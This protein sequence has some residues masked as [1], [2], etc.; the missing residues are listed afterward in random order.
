MALFN[1]G[2]ASIYLY[3]MMLLTDYWGENQFR[4]QIGWSLLFFLSFIVVVNFTKVLAQFYS[5]LSRKIKTHVINK[6]KKY[7][8]KQK[9]PTVAIKTEFQIDN[10]LTIT[11]S[12]DFSL[13]RIPPYERHM[14]NSSDYSTVGYTHLGRT[15]VINEDCINRDSNKFTPFTDPLS[16]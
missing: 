9:P 16:R 8:R 15:G 7:L 2:A 10:K 5:Y 4:D 12:Q 14:I 13:E 3:I 1:E 11:K 6:I